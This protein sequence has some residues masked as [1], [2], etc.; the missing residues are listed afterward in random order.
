MVDLWRSECGRGGELQRATG[1]YYHDPPD[2]YLPDLEPHESE[3]EAGV[4]VGEEGLAV[5][6]AMRQQRG[7]LQADEVSTHKQACVD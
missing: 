7:Q 5:D 6:R 3:D 4:P 1:R 2:A